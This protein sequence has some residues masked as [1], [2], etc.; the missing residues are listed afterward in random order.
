MGWKWGYNY[1]YKDRSQPHWCVPIMNESPNPYGAPQLSVPSNQG[2]PWRVILAVVIL[3]ITCLILAWEVL[4]LMSPR[5]KSFLGDVAAGNQVGMLFCTL[6]ITRPLCGL[7]ATW[8]IWTGRIRMGV[9]V[10][11]VGFAI[12]GL[13][14]VRAGMFLEM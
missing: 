8:L 11:L 6:Y 4:H 1:R 5:Y 2:R 7:L 13:I 10:L 9:W 3:V 14:V 12:W